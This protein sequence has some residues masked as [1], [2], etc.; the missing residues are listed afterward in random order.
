MRATTAEAR[1]RNRVA[2]R[3]RR[4]NSPIVVTPA[5]LRTWPLP[6]PSRGGSKDDRGRVLV[7]G[8]A[9][10]MPGA[11][12]LAANAALRAG[13]GK[14]QIATCASIAQ[15]VAVTV[16]EARVFSLPEGKSG[17]I[18]RSAAS[19][20]VA[21]AR[22]VQAVLIGPG[23]VDRRAVFRL[24]DALIPKLA[25]RKGPTVVIDAEPLS[26]VGAHRRALSALG[27]RVV[28][29]PHAGEMASM[30]DLSKS[31]VLAEAEA[32][33][34]RVAGELSAVVALKDAV[35]LIAAPDGRVF[36]NDAGNVGLA[37]SGSGDTLSGVVAGLAARGAEPLQAAV[38]GVHLHARA[39]EVLA[40]RLGPIGYL[41]RELLDEIPKRM[42]ALARPSRRR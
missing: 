29:T 3:V 22:E 9:P 34:R 11:V 7:V 14:L 41:A 16:P 32:I 4:G 23:M 27:G 2:A 25:G 37:T 33:A 6:Q 5:R 40:R 42:A 19:E 1:H 26:W 17:G 10:G 28:L 12:I 13:A 30:L 24:M 20:L 39:G 35:T 18:A 31:R 15:L 36:R 21:R 8:G 38:F